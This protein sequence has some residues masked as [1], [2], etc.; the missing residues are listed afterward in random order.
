MR[1]RPSDYGPDPDSELK[2]RR[3]FQAEKEMEG[4]EPVKSLWRN[5]EVQFA[6]LIE[7]CQAAGVFTPTLLDTLKQNM[8]LD[9][10][11][12]HELLSRAQHVFDSSKAKI[13]GDHGQA[14]REEFMQCVWKLADL[15]NIDDW[16]ECIAPLVEMLCTLRGWDYSQMLDEY[17]RKQD[18]R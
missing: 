6:R 1:Y 8:D 17:K 4:R 14:D 12:V 5:N 18:G 10:I 7:E 11:D 2:F 9:L 16:D 3:I 13:A 15:L